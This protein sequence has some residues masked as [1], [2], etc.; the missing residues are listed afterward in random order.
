MVR[1]GKVVLTLEKSPTG[2]SNSGKLKRPSFS[3]G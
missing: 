1:L 2:T 3:T